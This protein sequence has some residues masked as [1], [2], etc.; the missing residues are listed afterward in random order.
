LIESYL[1]FCREIRLLKPKTIKE[2]RYLIQR[3]G[4][5]IDWKNPGNQDAIERS[6]LQAKQAGNWSQNYTCKVS[7]GVLIPWFAWLSSQNIIP[8]NPY[9]HNRF[10][11]EKPNEPN[12]L[13]QQEFD[14]IVKDPRLSLQDRCLLNLAWDT[15][16]R[17][18]ELLSLDQPDIDL[19]ENL[20]KIR[21]TKGD[22]SNGRIVPFTPETNRLIAKQIKFVNIQ[23]IKDF[24][25]VD[26]DWNRLGESA[27]DKRI[28]EIGNMRS[29]K[30]GAVRFHLHALRHSFANRAIAAGL[31]QLTVMKILGHSSLAM[32]NQYLHHS[33]KDVK[34]AYEKMMVHG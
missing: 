11:K 1:T 13:T 8:F 22:Y 25:F 3:M 2:Y 26:S 15:G 14:F 9:L 30:R 12:H 32:T 17:K 27:C 29:P 31:E 21:K 16:A 28:R 33:A 24:V 4:K 19:S 6:I 20:I 10:K 23:G 18:S 7:A 5:L 34:T